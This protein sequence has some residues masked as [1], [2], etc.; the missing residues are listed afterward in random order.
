M[1][2]SY[3]G[4]VTPK[5]LEVLSLETEHAARFYE[6]RCYSRRRS[7]AAVLCWVTLAP[8]DA[9]LIAQMVQL[10]LHEEALARLELDAVEWGSLPPAHAPC[11]AA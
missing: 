2:N 3:L 9:V 4:I 1:A 8:Q 11:D 5:G 10:G 7:T 6:R